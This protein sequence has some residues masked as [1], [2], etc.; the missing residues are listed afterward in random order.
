[1]LSSSD[2]GGIRIQYSK[3]PFGRREAGFSP[4]AA[5][6]AG[7]HPA[8]ADPDAFA[9]AFANNGGHGGVNGG[10]HSPRGGGPL[11][12]ATGLMAGMAGSMAAQ[13]QQGGGG[14]PQGMVAPGGSSAFIGQ[15]GMEHVLGGDV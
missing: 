6:L 13:Q 8:A 10:Q 15:A 4:A 1:V 5:A 12:G 7:G 14:V 9:A 2:R 11:G 3:N